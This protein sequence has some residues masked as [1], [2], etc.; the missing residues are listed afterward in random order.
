MTTLE[1]PTFES[2][3]QE[4]EFWD[5]LDTADFMPDDDEWLHFNTPDRR[6]LRVAILPSIAEGLVEMAQ[7]QGVSIETLVNV[8][9]LEDLHELATTN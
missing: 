7:V 6:A 5:N 4:A 2:Y 3:E 8:L 1:M 9:L